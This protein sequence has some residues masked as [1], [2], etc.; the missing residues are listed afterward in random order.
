MK[1]AFRVD[2]S[3]TIGI[4][5]LRRCLALAQALS[6][7]GAQIAFV[8][9]DLGFDSAAEIVAFGYLAL[10][11]RSPPMHAALQTQDA[12]S[13]AHWAGVS[14]VVDADE[15]S[16][17][18]TAWRPDWVVVDHYAFD[19]GWHATVA[20]A[21]GARICVIDDLAD[22]ALNAD[23]L[24]DHNHAPDHRAKYG[25][26][27]AGIARLLGGPRFALLGPAYAEAGA[28]VL[29][30]RVDSIGIFM[31]GTDP[32][33]ASALALNA[34]REV[35][36]FGGVVQVATTHANPHLEALA[37]LCR[38]WPQTELLIDEPN[39]AAFFVRHDLQIG[40][41]GGA[42]WERCCVGAPTL[43]LA[44]AKNQQ[45]V[46]AALA[47]EGAVEPVE[48]VSIDTVG[49]AVARLVDDPAKRRQLS[50]RSRRLVG[51]LGAT[52]V[53]LALFADR[54]EL[55][56]AAMSDARLTHAW[57]N[58]LRTRRYFHNP[59]EVALDVHLAWWD[60]TLADSARRLLI[61]RCAG[62]DIGTV[63]LDIEGTEA[64]VSIYLDPQLTGLGLGTGLLHAAQRWLHQQEPEV[65]RLIAE[66]HPD[67]LASATAFRAAAFEYAGGHRWAWEKR[68]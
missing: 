17:L 20:T 35:A 34:C 30:D 58:D 44:M 42:S 61:A 60:H 67:N 12:P 36:A 37:A 23:V 1:T 16:A 9:R 10:T 54:I 63:R 29:R 15:T 31:G 47:A 53:A 51:A 14:Q 46:V 5:H 56:L 28:H 40:A 65:A 26:H 13:H 4:G 62:R 6:A 33:Q 43:A 41:G 3:T 50:E 25:L 11:L 52:R 22:R 7:L 27:A 57:R 64:E 49:R 8:T 59:A 39:L 21:T 66:I 68:R 45:P 32:W 18:L 55:R 19:A 38:R 24:V 48:F 2:A